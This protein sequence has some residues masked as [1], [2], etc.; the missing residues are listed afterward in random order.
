MSRSAFHSE[1][2]G[3][4]RAIPESLQAARSAFRN[5]R[6]ALTMHSATE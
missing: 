3:E 2:Y 5:R 1:R 6:F 4:T